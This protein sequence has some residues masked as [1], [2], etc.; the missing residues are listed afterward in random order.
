MPSKSVGAC[1]YVAS[2]I[3]LAA[4]VSPPSQPT[5]VE[6]RPV[7]QGPVVGASRAAPPGS[8][9]AAADASRDIARTDKRAFVK[10]F[11]EAVVFFLGEYHCAHGKHSLYKLYGDCN[12][13]PA[14]VLLKPGGCIGLLPYKSLWIHTP[15]ERTKITWQI[16]GPP[17][18][19]FDTNPDGIE[20]RPVPGDATPPTN[21][22]D[23]K[24][25]Q[26]R[27][28]KWE[29]KDA[30]VTPKEF[31]HLPNIVDTSTNPPTKCTPID[32][33]MINLVN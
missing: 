3:S 24:D 30:A 11:D 25:H 5:G 27:K 28:F 8:V 31:Y 12:D 19:A 10:T 6:S 9:I 13:I 18:Y 7:V 15:N 21:S 4:C 26:G 20:L 23:G 14:V 33:G 2:A 16:S 1:L 32:P 17:Q 29:L 22:Y